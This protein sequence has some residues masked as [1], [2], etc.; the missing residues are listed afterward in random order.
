MRNT[1]SGVA[2]GLATAAAIFTT[3]S[4]VSSSACGYSR[5]HHGGSQYGS[6]GGS[7]YGSYGGQE[8]NGFVSQRHER[9]GGR[10]PPYGRRSG[11]SD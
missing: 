8:S 6:Y 2:I 4:T 9:S 5:S 3:G 7:Q 1:V 10:E 11:S